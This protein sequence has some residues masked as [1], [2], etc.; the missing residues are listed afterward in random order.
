[1]DLILSLSTSVKKNPGAPPQY[2]LV[3]Q[4]HISREL[5]VPT[6]I[7]HTIPY[8]G[9]NKQSSTGK[10]PIFPLGEEIWQKCITCA[11]WKT[12]FCP[13]FW[14][15]FCAAMKVFDIYK[16]SSCFTA[17]QALRDVFFSQTQTSISWTCRHSRSL[18]IL[19]EQ[20]ILLKEFWDEIFGEKK[21]L[22]D[23]RMTD[24]AWVNEFPFT[25]ETSRYQIWS[26]VLF[27]PTL[28]SN[29]EVEKGGLSGD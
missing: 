12:N 21:S 15:N 18:W 17:V 27:V 5:E 14:T 28:S 25:S 29:M 9:M 26:C 10:L 19:V 16:A 23:W 11:N 8:Q 4:T 22:P 24:T 3:C 1:M 20:P 6:T 13:S 2:I 7:Q